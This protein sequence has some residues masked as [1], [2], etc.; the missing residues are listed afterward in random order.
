MILH[1]V[2]VKSFIRAISDDKIELNRSDKIEN[3][4]NVSLSANFLM[5]AWALKNEC[6][7]SG[8]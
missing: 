3:N 6:R 8:L 4:L 1:F 2:T 5:L 7:V